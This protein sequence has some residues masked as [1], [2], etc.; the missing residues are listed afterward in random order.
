MRGLLNEKNLIESINNIIT[1]PDKFI[2]IADKILAKAIIESINNKISS[3]R[4]KTENVDVIL[5]GNYGTTGIVENIIS[6]YNYTWSIP[7]KDT[8]ILKNNSQ[9]LE[10]KVSNVSNDLHITIF[11]KSKFYY[12]LEKCERADLFDYNE[13]IIFIKTI[14]PIIYGKRINLHFDPPITTVIEGNKVHLIKTNNLLS[15]YIDPEITSYEDVKYITEFSNYSDTIYNTITIKDIYKSPSMKIVNEFVLYTYDS[16]S[17][18]ISLVRDDVAID[19]KC[20]KIY[21][22]TIL[23]QK[24]VNY[25]MNKNLSKENVEK[26]ITGYQNAEMLV[27]IWKFCQVKKLKRGLLIPFI[28]L[29][30]V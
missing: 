15:I 4:I 1:P 22:P 29:F 16:P 2:S 30:S 12:E 24:L 10:I 14:I 27:K 18:P 19:L 13:V 6:F 26:L 11:K 3:S 25:F 7:D 5:D 28:F 9:K 23:I 17:K 21:I 20:N 8:Y